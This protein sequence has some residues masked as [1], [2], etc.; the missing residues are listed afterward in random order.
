MKTRLELSEPATSP[1][2]PA[3]P[4][5]A[6]RSAWK[7]WL[8]HYGI[9]LIFVALLVAASLSSPFF[10][11]VNNLLNVSR[12]VAII[13]IL[14]VGMTL[15]IL[16]A[17]IDLS[18][19]AVLSLV[20]LVVASLKGQPA[21]VGV[22]AA[23]VAG[24]ACGV[25]NGLLI[26]RG[27]VQPFIVT[28]GTMAAVTGAGLTY[29]AGQPIPRR[30]QGPGLRGARPGRRRADPG[31]VDGRRLHRGRRGAG[32][33]EVRAPPLRGGRQHRDDTTGRGQLLIASSRW[34]TC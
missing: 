3:A 27:K 16:T 22:V 9:V 10:L 17:G 4:R 7:I 23:L 24:A 14:S 25:L 29:S 2:K 11:T 21:A 12:Q 28:L 6:G 19:G 18:V 1:P 5:H 8:E 32:A 13:G 34:P 33:N 30:R 15:V 26:T 31:R 20:T